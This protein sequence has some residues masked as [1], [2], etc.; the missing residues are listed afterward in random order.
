VTGMNITPEIRW[1]DLET[2]G[3]IGQDPKTG[4]SLIVVPAFHGDDCDTWH[5]LWDY[6][7]EPKG[8]HIGALSEACRACE[9]AFL[10]EKNK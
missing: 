5:F 6:S 10:E 7:K 3:R 2:G 4:N 1:I 8:T 9:A